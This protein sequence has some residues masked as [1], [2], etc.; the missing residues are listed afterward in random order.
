MVIVL[1]RIIHLKKMSTTW[2]IREDKVV[3]PII[4]KIIF[5]RLEKQLESGFWVETRCWF[6]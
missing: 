1:Y 6:I 4:I 2:V 5:S 3:S